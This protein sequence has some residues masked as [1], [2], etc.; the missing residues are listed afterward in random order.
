MPRKMES[1]ESSGGGNSI[2]P[3]IKEK[4]M[5]QGRRWCFTWNNYD[6]NVV[7]AIKERLESKDI[8]RYI[9]GFEIGE[10]EKTPHLQ[11]YFEFTGQI[12]RRPS[13]MWDNYNLGRFFKCKGTAE[14]NHAYCSKSGNYFQG[15]DWSILKNKEPLPIEVLKDEDLYPFQKSIIDIIDGPVIKGHIHWI[16][17]LKGQNGKT[18][19]LRKLVVERNLKFTYGGKKADIINLIYNNKQYYLT[20]KNAAMV[21]NLG[22]SEDLEKVSYTSMEQISDG[23]IS[24]TK[25]ETG[26]FVMNHPH[27]IVLANGMP[28]IR[29]M[30]M[31]RWIIYKINDAKELERIEYES[32]SN[33]GSP[34]DDLDN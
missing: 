18:E 32:H 20:T 15:G 8:L 4:R 10:K 23:L 6:D 13:E 5:N 27:I 25:Y 22:R 26:C 3:P 2:P 30:T 9:V 1:L 16:C 34:L 24:N 17:D 19:L 31:S 28:S 12:A 7:T 29:S 33:L 14:E 21:Y 11:G